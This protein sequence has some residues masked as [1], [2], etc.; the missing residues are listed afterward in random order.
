[1]AFKHDDVIT[2]QFNKLTA[3]RARAAGEYEEARL[4]EDSDSVMYAADKIVEIDARIG[5]LNRIA[6]NFV[7]GQQRQQQANRYGLSADEVTIAR[8]IG[9][10]DAKLSNDDR[11]R[12][13][14]EQKGRY[15]QARRDGSY[16][17][18]QGSVRR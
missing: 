13:Y 18:D 15:Q 11:E 4:S 5:A 12:I 14:A 3:E 8:G 6:D 2:A 9:S 17:D 16:R 1:M 10:G 7:A